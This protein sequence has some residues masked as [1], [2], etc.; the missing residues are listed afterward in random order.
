[1]INNQVY[2][3]YIEVYSAYKRLYD[4]ESDFY[5]NVNPKPNTRE[6]EEDSDTKPNL[7][8]DNIVLGDFEI[9]AH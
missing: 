7:K 8:E 4:H 2:R 6:E 1:M 9:L 5:N 3:S